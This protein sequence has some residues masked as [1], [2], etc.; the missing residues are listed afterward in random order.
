MRGT[1]DSPVVSEG[2]F[3]MEARLPV[4][5]SMD[6]GVTLAAATG[7]R[8]VLTTRFDGYEPVALELG[9][10]TRRRGVN[11]LDREKWI[12]SCRNALQ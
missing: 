2:S 12:L 8:S 4:A 10:T 9:A 5:T 3:T 6:Y 7:G 1:F 11:P